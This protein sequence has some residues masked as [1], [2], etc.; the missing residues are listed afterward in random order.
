MDKRKMHTRLSLMI[1]AVASAL[2]FHSCVPTRVRDFESLS[3]DAPLTEMQ[4]RE[5]F[6]NGVFP[7]AAGRGMNPHADQ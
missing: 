1:V 2:C 3:I 4:K 7:A 6:E 5:L